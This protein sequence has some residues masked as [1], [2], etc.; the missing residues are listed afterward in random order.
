MRVAETVTL[1]SLRAVEEIDTNTVRDFLAARESVDDFQSVRTEVDALL[2]AKGTRYAKTLWKE[3][4]RQHTEATETPLNVVRELWGSEASLQIPR[5]AY[6]TGVR[7][8]LGEASSVTAKAVSN[9]FM[10]LLN[11]RFIELRGTAWVD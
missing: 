5:A 3:Y 7:R 11:K 4:D 2:E 10:E 6:D 8:M 9:D 1:D